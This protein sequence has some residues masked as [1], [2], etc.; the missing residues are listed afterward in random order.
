MFPTEFV[1]SRDDDRL[2]SIRGVVWC[3]VCEAAICI[4]VA[5]GFG[6]VALLPLA[7]RPHM[8]LQKDYSDKTGLPRRLS[9]VLFEWLL[10]VAPTILEQSLLERPMP[11]MPFFSRAGRL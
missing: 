10:L 4:V 5:V 7:W 3:V 1:D 11:F 9:D 6:V 2:A 8:D